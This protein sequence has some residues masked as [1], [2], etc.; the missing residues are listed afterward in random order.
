MGYF[1]NSLL[2]FGFQKKQ[3]SKIVIKDE[4]G[5]D[6]DITDYIQNLNN[7]INKKI[8]SNLGSEQANKVVITDANG[9]IT[10]IDGVVMNQGERNKLRDIINPLIY[11][12]VKPSYE[13]LSQVENPQQG[14]MYIVQFSEN[15]ENRYKEY[16]YCE[17]RWEC[18]GDVFNLTYSNPNPTTKTLGGINAG[19]T[20]SNK[21]IQ[22]MF[23]MLLY[24]YIAISGFSISTNISGAKEKGITL[25]ITKVKPN[26]THGSKAVNSYKIY[27]NSAY[28]NE[29]TSNTTGAEITGLDITSG[30][31][32]AKIS[33]GTTTLSASFAI[34]YVDPF[35]YGIATENATPTSEQILALTKVIEAKGAKTC[36]FTTV[37]KQH[38]IF[39]Y[40][41][42]YGNLKSILDEN[43]FE[44]FEN[45][46]KYT[47]DVAVKSGTVSYNVYIQKNEVILNSFPFTFKF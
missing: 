44:N 34:N 39:A 13:S 42:S 15:G 12:G 41:A 5:N 4:N 28:T 45:F 17:N 32:Y 40:P 8:N 46:Q 2:E 20:F 9:N 37:G 26:Y 10:T 14:W 36:S 24:P 16:V 11:K 43:G 47:I 21:T 29:I 31:V 38:P 1:F 25:T 6:I 27:S 18:L 23:D 19:T 33:D 3:I 22:E 35:F 7:E 30:V